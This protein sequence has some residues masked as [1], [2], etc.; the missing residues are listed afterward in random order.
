MAAPASNVIRNVKTL[1]IRNVHASNSNTLTVIHTDGTTAPELFKAALAAGEVLTYVEGLGWDIYA[2][3]G[4]H[5]AQAARLLFK[6]LD[7]DDTGGQ[8]VATAQPWFPTA[9]GVNVDGA[10]AYF[11]EGRL[12]TT[13][14][15]G[16]TSHTTGL[17]FGGTATL[18]SIDYEVLWR[19]GDANAA[20]AVNGLRITAATNTAVKAASTS[21]TEDTDLNVFGIVRI[22]AGGTFIPQFQYSV[23]PGGAPTVKRGTYFRMWPIGSNTIVSQ[24]TWG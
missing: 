19:T 10:T 17:L 1:N 14:A 23:A 8:N 7:A 12:V 4:S 24:G 3:D 9:G 2:S 15:A 11:F 16:V 18:T 5:K 21:A 6:C 22:N 13:R 20:A